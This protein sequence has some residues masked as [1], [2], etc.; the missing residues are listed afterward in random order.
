MKTSSRPALYSI[1]LAQ[2]D[3][4]DDGDARRDAPL[5]AATTLSPAIPGFHAMTGAD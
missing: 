1:W 3:S 5:V 2:A 4:N